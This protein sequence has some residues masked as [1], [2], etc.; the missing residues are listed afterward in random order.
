M[1]DTFKCSYLVK[2][3]AVHSKVYVWSDGENLITAFAGSANYTQSAFKGGLREYMVE[4]DPNTGFAYFR[5]L[6]SETIYCEHP[7]AEQEIIIYNDKLSERI[8]NRRRVNEELS[9]I[10]TESELAIEGLP[11]VH[12]SLL[13]RNGNLPPR[14]GLNWGQRPEYHRDP[15]QAYIRLPSDIYSGDFFPP[16]G[17]HFTIITDD[18]KIL[19]CTRAQDSAKAIECPQNNSLIGIYFRGRLGLNSGQIVMKDDLMR[20][21]KTYIDFYK[22]DEETYYMDFSQVSNPIN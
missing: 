20:Y 13:D 19:I 7:D 21:G 1:K 8:Q 11:H 6:I 4:C 22:L 15:N 2:S 14:S 3:P 16:R 5:N 17:E 9:T 12:V 18:R 10:S